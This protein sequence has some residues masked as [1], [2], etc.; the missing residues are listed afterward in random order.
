MRSKGLPIPSAATASYAESRKVLPMEML[1]EVNRSLCDQLDQSLSIDDCWRGFRVKAEDGTSAQKYGHPGQSKSLPT[2]LRAGYRM[3]VSSDRPSRPD[4]SQPW[5]TTR[6]FREH[7][8]NRRITRSRPVRN[9]PNKKRS[10]S[11][12]E[13]TLLLRRDS[14]TE[15]ERKRIHRAQ[16][17]SEKNGLSQRPENRPQRVATKVGKPTSTRPESSSGRRMGGA[18]R[19][20]G[21]ANHPNQRSKSRR[22][23]KD[24]LCGDNASQRKEI[25]L[26][27]SGLALRA[28]LGNRV[29]IPGHQNDDVYGN[30]RTKSPEMVRKEVLMR[31]IAYN[32]IRLLM[33]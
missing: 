25:P 4:R 24:S 12:R 6:F 26:G 9:L 8:R 20:D 33:L 22:Q 28:P 30:A 11:G 2:A 15:K 5:R 1:R 14:A 21:N 19:E 10:T 3:R 27:R 23:T 18:S 7:R 17:S 31:M 13:T 16:S 32:A 29:E